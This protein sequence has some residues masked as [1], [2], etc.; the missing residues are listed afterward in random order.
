MKKTLVAYSMLFLFAFTF[1][2]AFAMEARA[3]HLPYTC[4]VLEWCATGPPDVGKQGHWVWSWFNEEWVCT[5]D[6]PNPCDIW[7]ICADPNP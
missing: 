1:A 7:T 5:W 4:C 2:F 6:P 3:E